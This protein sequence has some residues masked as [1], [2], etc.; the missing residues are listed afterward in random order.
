MLQSRRPCTKWFIR[1]NQIPNASTCFCV[2]FLLSISVAP[3]LPRLS[4]SDSQTNGFLSFLSVG[5]RAQYIVLSNQ[6][7]YCQ[8]LQGAHSRNSSR[9]HADT[10]RKVLGISMYVLS[11]RSNR[12]SQTP[13]SANFFFPSGG[14]YSWSH[15]NGSS[16]RNFLAFADSFYF[17]LLINNTSHFW[18]LAEINALYRAT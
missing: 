10:R 14:K 7:H 18:I 15:A 6:L 12:S 16:F 4:D 1:V 13:T 5:T 3:Y 9:R 17:T 8:Q 2:M 11:L